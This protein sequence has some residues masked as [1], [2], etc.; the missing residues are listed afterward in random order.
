MDWQIYGQLYLWLSLWAD[1]VINKTILIDWGNSDDI[2]QIYKHE[3]IHDEKK[4]N[5]A[6]SCEIWYSP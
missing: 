2:E 6:T 3:A 1:I 5:C 4:Q